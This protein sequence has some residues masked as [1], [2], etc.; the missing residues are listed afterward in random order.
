MERRNGI[1][2]DRSRKRIFSITLY[3]MYLRFIL[4]CIGLLG[5]FLEFISLREVWV[6][7]SL[8]S[9]DFHSIEL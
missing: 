7:C 2:D 8:I 5:P 6:L 3:F 1:S 4:S 9:M